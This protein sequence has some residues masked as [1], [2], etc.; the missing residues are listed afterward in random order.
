M[1]D[2]Q[3]RKQAK[4]TI[5]GIRWF[6]YSN[7]LLGLRVNIQRTLIDA[8]AEHTG[9]ELDACGAIAS[10]ARP[11]IARLKAVGYTFGRSEGFVQVPFQATWHILILQRLACCSSTII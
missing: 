9:N 10:F 3:A 8:V 2:K 11:H 5:D 4:A 7:V 1:N 6:N